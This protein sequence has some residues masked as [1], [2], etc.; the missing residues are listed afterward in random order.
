VTFKELQKAIQSQP[1]LELNLHPILQ[2]FR[3]KRFWYWDDAR[4][5]DTDRANKGDCCF[6]HIIGLPTK[7]GV[8]KPIFDY[9]RE[10]YH[11]LTNPGH[12]NNYPSTNQWGI[13]RDNVLFPFKEKHLWIKKATGLG[14]TEFML[15]F[16]A[17]LRVRNNDYQNSQMVIVTGPNQELA[18]KLIKR[19]K[20]LFEHKLGVTS[21]SKETVLELNGCSIEAFP[22]NHIDAFRSLTN[23]K[24]ILIDEGDYFRKNEQD[25]VRHVAERYIAKS[26]PYIV[27]VSTPKAP[28]GLFDKIEKEPIEGCIYKKMFLDYTYGRDKIYTTAEIEK[29]KQ[30]PSFPREYELQYQGL[31]GNVFSQLCIENAT[32]IPYDPKKINQNAKKSVGID[33][34]FG[35]SKF[36]IVITQY[37]DGK[38]QVIHAEEYDRPNF[39]AMIDKIW[40]LKQQ[41]GYISNIYVDAANPEVWESLKRE[42]NEPFNQQYIRDQISE[43]R[44]Y[45]LHIEDRMIVV[46]V[47]FSIEGAKM[48]QHAK[49]LME[50]TDE[51]G[52]SLV[53]IRRDEFYKLITGLRTAVANEYKLS[54]EETSYNDLVVAFRLSLIFYK[55]SKG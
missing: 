33:P 19:M 24:F 30:S 21:D 12:L 52:S 25:D 48:L 5:K 50:E 22:S 26:D 2:R 13:K 40:Q 44:K 53:A 10:I 8:E 15:R 39:S 38:I 3:D 23:P 16:M 46:P 41:C 37:V 29:A 31:I 6:N 1:G 4:H 20:G 47:P 28:D 34:G 14:V 43:C 51:D 32:K 27:M 7:N 45:N 49:W 54:K 42:F 55:R 35:S 11:A 9:E 18:I 36:A 17:W